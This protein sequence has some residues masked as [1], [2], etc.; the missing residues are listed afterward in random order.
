MDILNWIIKGVF[1][2][3]CAVVIWHILCRVGWGFYFRKEK[4]DEA[5]RDSDRALRRAWPSPPQGGSGISSFANINR[6]SNRPPTTEYTGRNVT[7]TVDQTVINDE[8]SIHGTAI[9][10]LIPMRSNSDILWVENKKEAKQPEEKTPTAPKPT[11]RL[12]KK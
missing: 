11:I 8:D 7:S 5:K 10:S 12:I 9:D 2:F 1:Y 3:G 4:R 6:V